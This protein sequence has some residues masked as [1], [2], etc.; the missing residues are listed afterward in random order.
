[1]PTAE[2]IATGSTV[3]GCWLLGRVAYRRWRDAREAEFRAAHDLHDARSKAEV[4]LAAREPQTS[5]LLGA[6]ALLVALVFGV[7]AL[8]TSLSG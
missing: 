2:H 1:M 7:I 6:V 3:L 8:G 5:V 4:W